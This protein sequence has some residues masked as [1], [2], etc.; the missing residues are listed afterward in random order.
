MLGPWRWGFDLTDPAWLWGLAALP[1]LWWCSRRGLLHQAG[2]QRNASL[3]CRAAIVTLLVLILS[4]LTLRRPTREPFVVFA[5]DRSLSIGDEAESDARD[6]V[7]KALA[8]S[9]DGRAAFLAFA[10]RP[11]T[12]RADRAGALGEIDSEDARMGTDLAAAI[13]VAAG[14]VPAGYVPRVVLLTDGNATAGDARQAARRSGVPV[15]TVPL[16]ARTDPEIQVAEVVVPTQVRQEEPFPI[17]VIVNSNHDDDGILEIFCGNTKVPRVSETRRKVKKGENRFSFPYRL[18]QERDAIIRARI[19]GFQDTRLDDN[20]ARAMV[21]CLGKPRVLIVDSDPRQ[22]E[23]LADALTEE[24]IQVDPPRPPEGLPDSLAQLQNYDLVILA[25]VPAT[26][27]KL[28]Q[29]HFQQLRLYVQELGGGL[30]LIGGDHAF[31]PGGYARSAL[32]DLLPVYCSFRKEEEKPRLAMVLVLDK[33][34]SMAEG[35]KLPMVKDAAR[36]AVELLAAKDRVGVVAFDESPSWVSELRP[37]SEKA[38]VLDSLA[39][40]QAEGGTLILPALHN[41]YQALDNLGRAAKYKHVILLSDGGDNL[42]GANDDQFTAL[43]DQMSAAGVTV[44]CVGVGHDVDRDLL[45]HIAQRG[46]GRCYFPEELASVP[47]IFAQE[48]IQAGKDALIEQP[49]QPMQS[50]PSKVLAGIDWSLAPMLCG[51]VLTTIKPTSEQ[52]MVT[53]RY[54]PLLAWWRTGL[55]MC[56]AFT[57]DA[58]TRWAEPWISNWPTGF[59]RFWAQVARHLMRRQDQ[60]DYEIQIARRGRNVSVT[61]DAVDLLGE[62]QNDAET[63]LKILDP[64]DDERSL[65]VRQTAPGRY[66]SEFDASL[67]GDYFLQL[68]QTSQGQAVFQETRGFY[69]GYPDELRLRPPDEAALRE[70]AADSD[71]RFRPDPESVFAPSEAAATRDIALWPHLAMLAAAAFAGDVAL[72]RIDVVSI[73]AA[74][75]NILF[76]RTP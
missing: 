61:L 27:P 21:H 18:T 39:R 50:R 2:A 16:P 65:L 11:G 25:N 14:A 32:E 69:V 58:E 76:A 20:S 10:A 60:G 5:V 6:Y 70:L 43:L 26:H 46:G 29:K 22:A 37:C 57:S 64:R 74:A 1:L 3:F 40:I 52:V 33:S 47:Q 54:D 42:R 53:P 49:F 68:T 35:E 30:L 38:A 67:G 56:G 34:G 63:R 4:G 8:R 71:G 15:W 59:S 36:G 31:G 23:H 62:F 45:T 48:T 28:T 66:A 24:K 44:S 12:A 51:Y 55:G 9:D 72:R 75:R 13:E 17:E 41:A 7:D 73:I 19:T